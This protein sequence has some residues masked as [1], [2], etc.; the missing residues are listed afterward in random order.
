MVAKNRKLPSR[1][2]QGQESKGGSDWSVWVC[3]ARD[4]AKTIRAAKLEG[5]TE[6]ED[7][8]LSSQFTA[9]LF[10]LHRAV[11]DGWQSGSSPLC[12]WLEE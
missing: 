11:F 12:R 7:S 9:R 2:L 5:T 6:A 3:A 8:Q 10:G 1:P 4:A